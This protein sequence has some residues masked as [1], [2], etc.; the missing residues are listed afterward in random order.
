MSYGTKYL[1][2]LHAY[3]KIP[4]RIFLTSIHQQES[5]LCNKKRPFSYHLFH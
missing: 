3:L 1:Q 4:K 2:Q 5:V